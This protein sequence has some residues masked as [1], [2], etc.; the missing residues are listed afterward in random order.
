MSMRA[1]VVH[2]TTI[3]EGPLVWDDDRE[4]VL[5]DDRQGRVALRKRDASSVTVASD[6]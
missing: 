3:Y 5:D 4:I 2:G 6:R 1:V